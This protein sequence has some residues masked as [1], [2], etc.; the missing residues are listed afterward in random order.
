MRGTSTVFDVA[1]FLLLVSAAVATLTIPERPAPETDV[2]GVASTLGT[3]RTGVAY[4]VALTV[5][6]E[7]GSEETLDE[8]RTANGTVANLLADAAISKAGLDGAPVSGFE[9]FRRAVRNR[10]RRVLRWS[11]DRIRVEARWRPYLGAPLNGS[12]AVGPRPPSRAVT[13][14]TLDASGPVGTVRDRAREVASEGYGSIAEVVAGATVRGLFPARRMRLAVQGGGIDR[15]IAIRRYRRVL[16][17]LDLREAGSLEAGMVGSVN[18][19]IVGALADRFEADMR[20]RFESPSA[21]ARAVRAGRVRLIV[22][23]WEP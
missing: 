1:V 17:V 8:V 15:G 12:L 3:T 2:D 13:V 14:A 6:L 4:P 9:G 22:R 19:A 10:T 16:D 7:N 23:G 20:R 11:G 5:S 18:G 21:A